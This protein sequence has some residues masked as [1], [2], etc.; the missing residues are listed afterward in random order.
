MNVKVNGGYLHEVDVVMSDH[1]IRSKYI[2][3]AKGSDEA[4]EKVR[5]LNQKLTEVGE[6]ILPI[7][8]TYALYAMCIELEHDVYEV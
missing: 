8:E 1:S 2:V 5:I 3:V 6:P 4:V 7:N